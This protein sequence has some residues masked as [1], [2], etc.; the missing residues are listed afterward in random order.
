MPMTP[1]STNALICHFQLQFIAFRLRYLVCSVRRNFSLSLFINLLNLFSVSSF[2]HNAFST[3]AR[4]LLHRGA[5]RP[6]ALLCKAV[7]VKR[8]EGDPDESHKLSFCAYLNTP[9]ARLL[10]PA[11]HSHLTC[12][13]LCLSFFIALIKILSLAR[14]A[15]ILLQQSVCFFPP[16]LP[17]MD[18][19]CF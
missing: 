6:S 5:I 9:L 11:S 19:F 13:I 17:A 7:K 10:S 1:C 18:E 3:V 4:R 15:I 14:L 16:L 12:F 8:D 2:S